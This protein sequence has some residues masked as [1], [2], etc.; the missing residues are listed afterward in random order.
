MFYFGV[1]YYPEQ[2]P[3]QRWPEDARLMAE[4]GFNLVRLAEFAW[5][6]IEPNEGSYDFDWLDRAI[7]ILA[8]HGMR[9]VLGTPTASPPPWLMTKHPAIFRVRD[10]GIP[11]TF[12]NR[13]E[14]CPNHPIYHD[15]TR[16]I[17]T[18]LAEHYATH[19]QIIGW[20]IDNEFGERCYCP[21][22]AHAFQDWLH[23]RYGS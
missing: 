13:R 8:S 17:V 1:D 23:C 18:R 9:V 22:C 5:S 21:I 14:Y 12:G 7:A 20:Q 10:D 6:K 15:Y 19:P 11:L 16:R 3:K 4:A 2:W